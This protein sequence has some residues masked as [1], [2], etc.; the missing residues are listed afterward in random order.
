MVTAAN[1]AIVSC[2]AMISS[3]VAGLNCGSPPHARAAPGAGEVEDAGEVEGAGEDEAAEA[4]ATG[5]PVEGTAASC[6]A[7]TCGATSCGAT[8]AGR[9]KTGD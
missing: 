8:T 7:T 9:R 4:W 3:A 6:G 1:G 5:G 2:P